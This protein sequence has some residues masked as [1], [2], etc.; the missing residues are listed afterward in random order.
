MALLGLCCCPQAFSSCCKQG[1]LSS[2]GVWASR[3]VFFC[4]K[5][6]ALMPKLQWLWYTGLLAMWHVE[7]SW[8][9]DRTHVPCI[10]RWLLN[11]WTTWEVLYIILTCSFVNLNF[12]FFVYLRSSGLCFLKTYCESYLWPSVIL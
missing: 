4:C 1:Q 8:T 7:S 3:G 10:G 9:R 11:H 5:A 6:Q 2:C 12:F